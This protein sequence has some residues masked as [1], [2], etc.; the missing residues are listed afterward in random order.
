MHYVVLH[1]PAEILKAFPEID[2]IWRG[3]YVVLKPLYTLHCIH[4]A[5]QN[6]QAAHTV[7]TYAPHTIR[8]AGFWTE[9]A[10]R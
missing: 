7:Y 4:S 9:H 8:D 6:M 3:A 5:F 2:V 10:E 1:C